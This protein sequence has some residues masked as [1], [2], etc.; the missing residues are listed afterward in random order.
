MGCVERR[1]TGGERRVKGAG[2]HRGAGSARRAE[3]ARQA[4][5]RI[6]WLTESCAGDKGCARRRSIAPPYSSECRASQAGHV[7]SQTGFVRVKSHRSQSACGCFLSWLHPPPAPAPA[8]APRSPR[9]HGSLH[10]GWLK[11]Q[12]VSSAAAPQA[13]PAHEWAH[14]LLSRER[15]CSCG[16]SGR[17]PGH[18]CRLSWQPC[19]P[20][21]GSPCGT[22][23]GMRRRHT[24]AMVC[25]SYITCTA[26]RAAGGARV[27]SSLRGWWM[28]RAGHGTAPLRRQRPAPSSA[29]AAGSCGR[30]VPARP[31]H[32]HFLL[33]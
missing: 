16:G 26:P 3:G 17:A 5:G 10:T 14:A 12:P 31:A 23:C 29:P 9:C 24:S 21:L 32:R 7:S 28:G 19:S 15:A 13:G 27:A 20:G 8:A 33:R 2:R 6:K 22:R 30:G 4:G 11:G 1:W 18:S 25:A